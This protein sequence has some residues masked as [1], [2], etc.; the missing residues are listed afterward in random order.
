MTPKAL[1]VVAAAVLA[2]GCDLPYIEYSRVPPDMKAVIDACARAGGR[3]SGPHINNISYRI[4]C[5]I[6]RK[7][8]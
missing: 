3:P 8:K 4:T 7:D 5:S 2:C 6:D 1:F